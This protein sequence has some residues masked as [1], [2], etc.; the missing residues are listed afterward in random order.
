[1]VKIG[2][3]GGTD[4]IIRSHA[5]RHSHTGYTGK[6]PPQGLSLKVGNDPGEFS[7]H[8]KEG[9][10]R[11]LPQIPAVRKKASLR[12]SSTPGRTPPHHSK[13]LKTYTFTEAIEAKDQ[14]PAKSTAK[15]DSVLI[16]NEAG[17][18]VSFC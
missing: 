10:G 18:E 8:K 6:I 14:K 9:S 2:G 1:M 11:Q 17:E 16:D 13:Q 7:I 5:K 12:Q 4:E 15:K 3:I